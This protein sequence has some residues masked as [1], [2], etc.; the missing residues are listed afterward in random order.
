MTAFF[1]STIGLPY[2]WAWFLATII[3][4]LAFAGIG[5]TA[6]TARTGFI[7]RRAGSLMSA[8]QELMMS[9]DALLDRWFTSERLKAALAW[10]G[11]QSGPPMNAPGTAP[12]VGFAALMHRIPPGRAVG[13]SGAL[14]ST[15]RPVRGWG[16]TIRRASRCSRF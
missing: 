16:M 6:H 12:M 10:F 8:T 4:I 11:A 2:G 13:G 5:H 14:T 9:G 15:G 7:G 1:E 3:G